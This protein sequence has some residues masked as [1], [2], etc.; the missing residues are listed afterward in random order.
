MI[1]NAPPFNP[2]EPDR[3]RVTV[4]RHV[5]HVSI[6]LDEAQSLGRW[7]VGAQLPPGQSSFRRKEKRAMFG[8]E[9]PSSAIESGQ[10]VAI[11]DFQR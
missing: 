6:D 7:G 5:S 9:R 1:A 8:S 2:E 3:V 10:P 11:F 4:G